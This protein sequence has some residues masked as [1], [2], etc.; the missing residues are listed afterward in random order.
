MR[1]RYLACVAGLLAC[2]GAQ[3]QFAP[4]AGQAGSTAISATDSRFIDWAN[5]CIVNRGY[6]NIAEP[7]LGLAA[8]GDSSLAIGPA[9]DQSVSLGDSGIAVL[10]FAHPIYNGPG[11]DFAV[12]ENGFLN[13]ADPTQAFLELGFVEVSS[14][15]VNF[16]RFPATSLTSDS[17][18]VSTYGYMDAT[19]INNLAGKYVALYG[20]PF[21]L[22]ELAGVPGL[23]VDDVKYVR[24]VDVIG[25]IKG[26]VTADSAGRVVNDPYPTPF[27]T[28]GFD[29]DAVGVINEK[30]TST[31]MVHASASV[32]IYPNPTHA[33]LFIDATGVPD[34]SIV[35]ISDVAGMTLANHPLNSGYAAIQVADL[36]PGVY[37]AT[38]INN[39]GIKWT[40]KF[41][42]Y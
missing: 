33:S 10:S 30:G 31:E 15:G 17:V 36:N 13:P 41:T 34:A 24:I 26:I 40:A 23:D 16:F 37:L 18:Q 12:F 14:D 20:T 4:Q 25:N 38:I 1:F 11:Y 35:V 22:A 29:L 8:A 3:A 21:D 2:L 32:S 5:H 9:D 27:A 6:M 28:C 39:Q 19:K 7:T 42:K